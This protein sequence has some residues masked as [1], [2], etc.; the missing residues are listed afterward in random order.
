M[1]GAFGTS[2]DMSLTYW[3]F[4]VSGIAW[5]PC[6]G[7]GDGAASDIIALHLIQAPGR[8]PE[9]GRLARRRRPR[10]PAPAGPVASLPPMSAGLRT[11]HEVLGRRGA[12]VESQPVAVADT[13][14]GE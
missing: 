1:R 11:P 9:R 2:N 6:G 10:H 8:H 14:S 4:T 5:P 13:R 3:I 7:S 12:K